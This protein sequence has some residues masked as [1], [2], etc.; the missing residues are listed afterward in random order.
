MGQ[1][2]AGFWIWNCISAGRATSRCLEDW[3]VLSDAG[4][5]SATGEHWSI[6]VACCDVGS[7]I[8]LADRFCS[9][10]TLKV[11]GLTYSQVREETTMSILS[12]LAFAL[13]F[14]HCCVSVGLL[15]TTDPVSFLLF[16]F[17]S[18]PRLFS[19][20]FPLLLPSL[21]L[22]FHSFSPFLVVY[23]GFTTVWSDESGMMLPRQN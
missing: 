21:L 13:N 16:L 20:L 3:L 15:L 9:M 2:G 22:F 12:K 1:Q 18:F 5:K 7:S 8:R 17:S 14:V 10:R 6:L 23:S 11:D 4:M 19:F